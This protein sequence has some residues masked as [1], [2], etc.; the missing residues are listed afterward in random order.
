MIFQVL[1]LALPDLG[2]PAFVIEACV[3]KIVE[4]QVGIAVRPLLLW[5]FGR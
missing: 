2:K 3:K 4:R 5:V 1:A